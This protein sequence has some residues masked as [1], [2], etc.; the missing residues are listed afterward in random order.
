MSDAPPDFFESNSLKQLLKISDAAMDQAMGLAYQLYLSGRFQEADVICRGLIAC[1]QRYW[2][3]HSLHASILRRLGRPR[4]ALIA[5]QEG[6]K[7]EPRQPKLL[8]MR[9]ELLFNLARAEAK[10][11]SAGA[12]PTVIEEASTQAGH[13][14]TAPGSVKAA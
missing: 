9:A 8:L 13:T 4:E 6:L 3:P 14:G 12:V 11:N 5:V 10:E 1:D 2:W 7:H